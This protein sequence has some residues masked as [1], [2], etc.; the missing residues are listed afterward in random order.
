M[1]P[2]LIQQWMDGYPD[3]NEVI[4][5]TPILKEGKSPGADGIYP[6]IIKGGGPELLRALY[7]II[8]EA[9]KHRHCSLRLEGFTTDNHLQKR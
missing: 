6:E 8:I 4:Q 5:A 3:I 9:W 7:Y 2:S 1:E